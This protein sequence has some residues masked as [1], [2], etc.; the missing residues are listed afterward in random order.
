MLIR[1]QDK[2]HLLPI[3]KLSVEQ[4]G[5]SSEFFDTEHKHHI[6]CDGM[7]IGGYSIKEKALEVLDMIQEQNDTNEWSKVLYVGSAKMGQNTVPSMTFEMPQ[8]DEV[9]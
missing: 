8:D 7:N 1:S 2:M 4:F 3:S 9:N 5:N 6:V